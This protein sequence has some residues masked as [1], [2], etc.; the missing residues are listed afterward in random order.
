MLASLA[1]CDTVPKH[2]TVVFSHH[3]PRNSTNIAHFYCNELS[4]EVIN[5]S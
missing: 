3:M 4:V 5:R 2:F 1:V